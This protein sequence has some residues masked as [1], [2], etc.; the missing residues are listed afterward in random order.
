MSVL[1]PSNLRTLPLRP[2]TPVLL[3]PDVLGSFE[4]ERKARPPSSGSGCSIEDA[5][6][7]LVEGG[8]ERALQQAPAEAA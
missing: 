6:L 4:R 5:I 1:T 8:H 7:S 3:A 2:H